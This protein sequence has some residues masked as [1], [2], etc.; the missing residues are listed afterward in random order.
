MLLRKIIAR[1]LLLQASRL[2]RMDNE[3][4]REHHPL[5]TKTTILRTIDL[6]SRIWTQYPPAD[7]APRCDTATSP[8]LLRRPRPPRT[9]AAGMAPAATATPPG[10]PPNP[11]PGHRQQWRPHRQQ[12][13]IVTFLVLPLSRRRQGPPVRP[14]C[15]RRGSPRS[16]R[17]CCWVRHR[18]CCSRRRL[19]RR[20]RYG[21]PATTRR[22]AFRT[23]KGRGGW[24][25]A[26]HL[27]WEMIEQ[28]K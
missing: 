25:G 16:G 14:L 10:P 11:H 6:L 13:R 2:S 17:R 21:R 8:C 15:L 22:G 7:T 3:T 23:R 24:E 12:F 28:Y 18:R 26:H 20:R 5:Q 4:H 1:G 19:R 27:N 9:Q